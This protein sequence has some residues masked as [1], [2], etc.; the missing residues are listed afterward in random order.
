MGIG[1][2]D[3]R[4]IQK[5]TSKEFTKWLYIE[6]P[7]NMDNVARAVRK[8]LEPYIKRVIDQSYAVI[9]KAKD[10]DSIFDFKLEVEDKPGPWSAPW[11]APT[12]TPTTSETATPTKKPLDSPAVDKEFGDADV[13]TLPPTSGT[14]STTSGKSPVDSDST[15]TSEISELY[16]LASKKSLS[17]H[18]EVIGESGPPHNK[19]YSTRYDMTRQ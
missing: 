17:V 4:A 8:N 5:R 11:T 1:I 19:T 6:E 10:L 15:P 13:E 12:K 16:E 2:R 9:S 3:A 7:Y 18:F 14:S